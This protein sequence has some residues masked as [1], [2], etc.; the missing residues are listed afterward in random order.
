MGARVR[1]ATKYRAYSWKFHSADDYGATD[2]AITDR[3]GRFSV[4]TD[5][6]ASFTV[7][8]PGQAP[9]LIND[10]RKDTLLANGDEPDAIRLPAGI[11]IKGR[12]L[13]DSGKPVPR[14]IVTARR[15]VTWNEFD[16]PLSFSI[17]CAADEFG[18]YELPPLPADKFKLSISDQLTEDCNPAEYNRFISSF[19][20]EN[21]PLIETRPLDLVFVPADITLASPAVSPALD[22]L[23]SPMVTLQ[24]N[25]EFPDGPPDPDRHSD[26]GVTGTFKG[27]P[28]NGR[29]VKADEN[30]IATL[31]AP[32][33]LE[34]AAIK[35][36]LARHHRSSDSTIEIGEAIHFKR[37]DENVSGVTVIKPRLATLK[38]KLTLSSSVQ[39]EIVDSKA[40]VTIS[41]AYA[42]KGFREQSSDRQRI[43]LTGATQSGSNEYRGT[44]LPNEPIIVSVIAIKDGDQR[45]IHEEQ[46]TLA[47][48]EE[49]LREITVGDEER[50]A[51]DE[52]TGAAA[53]ERAVDYLLKQ[54]QTNGAWQGGVEGTTHSDGTTALI[55]LALFDRG[56]E[57][58][59]AIQSATQFLLKASPNMT[60]EVALQAM[61]LHRLGKPGAALCRQS[62]QWLV[63][64]QIKQ[65]AD[66]GGW[67][68]RQDPVGSRA[69]G[70]NSAYAILALTTVVPHDP[71]SSSAV[72]PEVWQRSVDWLVHTQLQD[73]GWG[74][75]RQVSV[76]E[77]MTACAVAGLKSLSSRVEKN[78]KIDQAILKGENW[79][80]TNWDNG[81]NSGNSAWKLLYLEWLSRA[82]NDR[83]KLGDRDW[84][85]DI[86]QTVLPAQ[87]QNGSFQTVPASTHP[88]VSTAFAI[89]ILKRTKSSA[90]TR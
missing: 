67:G 68:Y 78:P 4:S 16:M 82:L 73:G 83:P 15:D 57:S 29:Y 58:D 70:A 35:T 31:R 61:F 34:W 33:G 44:A 37:L 66:A 89:E 8:M 3:A 60:K 36:G 72:S 9:L 51:T 11:S 25:V 49:R 86:L 55:A 84:R 22:L 5:E 1:T 10:L 90:E 64:A 32:L 14:A 39:R 62:V 74:Y 85:A 69:D 21:K 77:S 17:S 2:E 76:S 75:L 40:R 38:V 63:D 87:Q 80:A 54:Q 28:W 48:G 30:G 20:T 23:A 53:V 7:M 45:T 71:G 24:V 6:P 65:G 52:P 41:A 56:T 19:S 81:R 18:H 12:V 43:S 13:T 26:V 27:Q 42:R 46:L 50:N 59:Q 88:A 47:P 79:L